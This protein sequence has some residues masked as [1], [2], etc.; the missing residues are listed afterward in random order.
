M[1]DGHDDGVMMGMMMAFEGRTSMGMMKALA[2]VIV[3]VCIA[4]RV[5]W[6]QGREHGRQEVKISQRKLKRTVG[7]QSQTTYKFAHTAP[8]FAVLPE[9]SQGCFA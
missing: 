9:A 5:S 3:L 2:I 4:C 1:Y 7:T 6:Q 8:R